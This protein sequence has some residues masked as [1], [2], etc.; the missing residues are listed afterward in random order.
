MKLLFEFRQ[1]GCGDGLADPAG[2][3]VRHMHGD[4]GGSFGEFFR[5]L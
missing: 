1:A 4:S 5:A 2:F 3:L